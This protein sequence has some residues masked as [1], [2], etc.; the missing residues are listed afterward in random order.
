MASTLSVAEV[1]PSG[2]PHL[3][4]AVALARVEPSGTA[5]QHSAVAVAELAPVGAPYH[6]KLVAVTQVAPV[7]VRHYTR[8]V[9]VTRVWV[10]LGDFPSVESVVRYR[11]GDQWIPPTAEWIRQGGVWLELL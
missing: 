5:H 1:S 3:H 11:R 8:S 10:Q 4:S 9:A 7:G 6:R 2:D